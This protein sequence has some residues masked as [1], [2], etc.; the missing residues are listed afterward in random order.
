MCSVDFRGVELSKCI[1]EKR[2]QNVVVIVVFVTV[3]GAE[4]HWAFEW[5]TKVRLRGELVAAVNGGAV[6]KSGDVQG[7]LKLKSCAVPPVLRP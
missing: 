4:S 3:G 6:A 1:S 2:E 7:G 5:I